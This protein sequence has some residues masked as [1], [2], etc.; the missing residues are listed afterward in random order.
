MDIYRY[1]LSL[2][3]YNLFKIVQSCQDFR[4][5]RAPDKKQYYT[6]AAITSVPVSVGF[7]VDVFAIVG[8]K[9]E[10]LHSLNFLVAT[11]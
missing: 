2:Q 5:L 7:Q 8:C 4:K 6:S 3:S 10:I 9:A 11:H 1:N